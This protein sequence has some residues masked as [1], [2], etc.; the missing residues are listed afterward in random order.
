VV[1]LRAVTVMLAWMVT[2]EVLT[3]LWYR[4][5]ESNA[6][7]NAHWRAAWPEVPEKAQAVPIDSTVL[8]MLRCND[9]KSGAWQDGIGNRWQ[10][11]FF[12]WPPGRNSA[13]LASAHTPDICLR[14]V[15]YKLMSD[16]GVRNIS[17]E[18]LVLPFHQYMFTKGRVQLHVFYCRWEDQRFAQA[19]ESVLRED[20]SQWSRLD[21][22]RAG[23]R[24][25]GQQVLEITVNGPDTAEVAL[26]ALT[27]E[28]PRIIRR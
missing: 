5:H 8:A 28:L 13:Q 4:I 17:L 15:G 7:E 27:S 22:V 26:A 12:R 16:L 23:Q 24:H 2:A 3:Q 6:V 9:G 21:A 25:R 11:F 1:P 10:A 20:G 19:H 18:D 14:G